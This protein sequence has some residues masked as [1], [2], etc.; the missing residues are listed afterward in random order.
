MKDW[1]KLFQRQLKKQ[2]GSVDNI[3]ENLRPFLKTVSDT[4]DHQDKERKMLERS[5]ELSS[6]EM[7]ELNQ[8]LRKET[9]TNNKI[10]FEKIKESLVLINEDIPEAKFS[11]EDIT[12]THIAETL[13]KETNKRRSIENQLI[14]ANRM[15]RVISHINQM[16]VRV[17]NAADIFNDACDI[18]VKYGRFK[19]AWVSTIVNGSLEIQASGGEDSGLTLLAQTTEIL[20]QETINRA[21]Y[22]VCN[23]LL[24]E[25]NIHSQTLWMKDLNYGSC[26]ILPLSCSG[27]VIGTFNLYVE[28]TNFFNNEEIALLLEAAGDMSFALEVINKDLKRVL[29]ERKL[30]S[31]EWRLRQAQA[32]AHLGS[33]SLDFESGIAMWSKE[34]L[35]IYGID[36]AQVEQSYESWLSYVYPDDLEYVIENSRQGRS[37][38]SRTAFFHRIIRKDGIVRHLYSQSDFEYDN[39]GNPIGLYGVVHDVTDIKI[40]EQALSDSQ[41][42]L[43]AIFNSTSEG[44]IL[45]GLDCIV[46]AYNDKA[47]EIMASTTGLNI[48]IGQDLRNLAH[49]TGKGTYGDLVAVV[50][51]GK[52]LQFELPF[53]KKNRSIKWLDFIVSPVFDSEVTTG[54]V[55]TATDITERKISELKLVES[56]KRYRDVFHFSPLPMWVYDQK[57]LR[58]LDVNQSAIEQYGY[59]KKQF[60]AMTI[61]DIRPEDD[62]SL[63]ND[64]I[65][66]IN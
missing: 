38:L 19:T 6:A 59:T 58:F 56:E 15:F 13:R 4:Y 21:S 49:P 43:Q 1:N 10:V 30:Q 9:D 35:K 31:S 32:I 39:Q 42:D 61:Q 51:A 20:Q 36:P 11:S 55:I 46:K 27:G 48:C 40:A 3:P 7:K 37:S 57:D 29:T 25:V 18:V 34:A 17:K 8:S 60:L 63:L 66:K 5:I 54:M 44:F 14:S 23:N 65:I 50:A 33:W 64:A 2:F 47:L 62:I 22:Y 12:L 24:T 41:A 45:T 26:I 53:R 28:G 16:I 52:R